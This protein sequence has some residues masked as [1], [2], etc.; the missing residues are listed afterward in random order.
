MGRP[1]QQLCGGDHS[2]ANKEKP[3]AGSEDGGEGKTSIR[4]QKMEVKETA[5]NGDQKTGLGCLF[6]F[7]LQS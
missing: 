1:S 4:G 5:S 3:P 2:D 6:H 7:I